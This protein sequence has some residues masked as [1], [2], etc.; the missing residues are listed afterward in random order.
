M[1]TNKINPYTICK[2]KIQRFCLCCTKIQQLPCFPQHT[3][4]IKKVLYLFSNQSSHLAPVSPCLIVCSYNIAFE[5]PT[6]CNSLPVFP[7]LIDCPNVIFRHIIFVSNIQ[8][9]TLLVFF[10]IL[11]GL[12]YIGNRVLQ[13]Q[14]M[15]H[16][17]ILIAN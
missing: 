16:N 10:F 1:Y 15:L 9:Q 3:F 17:V 11:P 12:Q 7:C 14:I 2:K 5:Y 6:I 8:F 13:L 4:V